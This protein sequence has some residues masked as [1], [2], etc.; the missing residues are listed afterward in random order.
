[1]LE[2]NLL[3]RITEEALGVARMEDRSV[4]ASI[5]Q[6][7]NSFTAT[8][9]RHTDPNQGRAAA[10]DGVGKR[11]RRVNVAEESHAVTR[12]RHTAAATTP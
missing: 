11:T 1:M 3:Q 4:C 2:V 12:V 10:D 6:K 9:K 5:D 8:V 7:G